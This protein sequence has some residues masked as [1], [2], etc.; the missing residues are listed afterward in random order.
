[1]ARSAPA[2]T[3]FSPDQKETVQVASM[4]L[5]V[6]DKASGGT[7]GERPG[8]NTGATRRERTERDQGDRE[9]ADP[10]SPFGSTGR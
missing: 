8:C 6:L 4:E 9:E 7:F 3:V 2:A 10:A 1:M 5:A